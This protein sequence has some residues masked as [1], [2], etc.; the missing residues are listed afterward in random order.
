[1]KTGRRQRA[2]LSIDSPAGEPPAATKE[3]T[4]EPS[5]GERWRLID[6]KTG[7]DVSVSTLLSPEL[8]LRSVR[9]AASGPV[10]IGGGPGNLGSDER[11]LDLLFITITINLG[12]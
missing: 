6:S 7:E 4:T 12:G 11:R 10:L 3:G 9:Q 2:L 8:C 5:P 1:M